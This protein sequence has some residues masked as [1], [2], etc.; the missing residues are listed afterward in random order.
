MDENTGSFVLVS[1]RYPKRCSTLQMS[2]QRSDW[3]ERLHA[4]PS[5]MEQEL[6]IRLQEDGITYL[7]R[8]I[9]LSATPLSGPE[10]LRDLGTLLPAWTWQCWVRP[11][12]CLGSAVEVG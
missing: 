2:S 7:N 4:N 10:W 5:R 3:R 8:T 1:E 9:A 12:L 11:M 6:A